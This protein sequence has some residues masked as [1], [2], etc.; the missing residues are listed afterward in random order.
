[1]TLKSV[2]PRFRGDDEKKAKATGVAG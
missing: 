1:M 2:Y